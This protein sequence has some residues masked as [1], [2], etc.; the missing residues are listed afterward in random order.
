M[1]LLRLSEGT[2]LS[3]T[4]DPCRPARAKS[5]LARDLHAAPP[6]PV[7]A[8]DVRSMGRDAS[9]A[10]IDMTK[11]LRCIFGFHAWRAARNDDG[12]PYKE[13]ARCDAAEE[14]FNVADMGSGNGTMGPAGF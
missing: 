3:G 4:M 6:H 10:D 14:R 11:P 2:V 7:I 13:C 9:R 12:E 8:G 1:P 5:Q